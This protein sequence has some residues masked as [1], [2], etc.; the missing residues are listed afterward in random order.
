MK[1]LTHT[2]ASHR[3]GFTLIELLVVISIIAILIALLLP[4]IHA[5]RQ[6]AQTTQCKN[7][8]KN[9]GTSMN[10]FAAG[11]AEERYSTGAF[12]FTRDGCPDTWG[13]VADMVKIKAGLPNN[14]R[15][16]TN[17]AR[18]SEKLNDLLGK[19]TADAG[20]ECPP[21][22]LSDGS[23]ATITALAANSAARGTAIDDN[24][25]NK[26]F[27]TNYSTSW[28]F[29]R[30]GPS[31]FPNK[32]TTSAPIPAVACSTGMKGL[33][34]TK[35]PLSRRFVDRADV[36]SSNIPTH[37]DAAQGDDKDAFLTT[38]INT[39][40]TAGTILAETQ[41]DGPSVGNVQGGIKK[42]PFL[43]IT[44]SIPVESFI[45]ATYPKLGV[46]V[47]DQAATPGT[48]EVLESAYAGS[49]ANWSAETSN[50]LASGTIKKLVLNDTRD[51][52]AVHGSQGNLLMVDGSVRS[53]NDTNGDG[54]FNPGFPCNGGDAKTSGYTTG[55]VEINNGEV[56][57]G[58]ILNFKSYLKGG[59]E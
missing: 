3:R 15:C 4:A 1:S 13:W 58:P 24:I 55:L 38:T 2:R 50:S 29:G 52:F 28:F 9:I 49:T 36:P 43:K 33:K 46:V 12:D 19:S 17:R 23:C 53:L 37:G 51:W 30:S 54:F 34:D 21:S 7:N 48:G 16:P 25:V 35:G 39:E 6:S 11:D 18:G 57:L 31:N 22:R 45:P 5:A 42:V 40:L 32:G 41:C 56:F 14:L 20:D 59:F 47:V 10:T 26:G 44:G 27:N 8:L